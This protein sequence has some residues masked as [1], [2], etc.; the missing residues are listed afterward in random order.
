MISARESVV[1]WKPNQIF[2]KSDREGDDSQEKSP[3][4]FLCRSPDDLVKVRGIAFDQNWEL[5]LGPITTLTGSPKHG[6]LFWTM[7]TGL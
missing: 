3:F 5:R 1:I 4:R 6:G 2:E 7:V